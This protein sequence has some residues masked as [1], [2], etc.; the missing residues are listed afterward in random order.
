VLA[1]PVLL[2][3]VVILAGWCIIG[4][5]PGL[6]ALG[7]TYYP[8]YM[9]STGIGWGLG[10]GRVGAIV[11]PYI[12]GQLMDL[13]WSSQQLFLVF[14]MPAVI[15]TLVMLSLHMI[16]KTPREPALPLEEGAG[17]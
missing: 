1:V 10:I 14:A 6:N 8:T 3:A 2:T 4:G 5:Q 15:S 12:G 16:F 9:R 13:D 17:P 7:A 11:G